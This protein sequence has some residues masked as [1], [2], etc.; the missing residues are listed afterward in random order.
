MNLAL[1]DEACS[2]A[3]G[4]R[5]DH[6]THHNRLHDLCPCGDIYRR[7]DIRIT[8]MLARDTLKVGLGFAV[9]FLGMSAG[10]TGARG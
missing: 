3:P 7:V 10:A 5:S 4:I 1:K 8:S 6:C 9:G 2:C